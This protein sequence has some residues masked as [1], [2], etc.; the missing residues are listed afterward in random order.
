MA[1]STVISSVVEVRFFEVDRGFPGVVEG[2]NGA[3]ALCGR[4]VGA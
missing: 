4:E 2:V 3:P 1:A